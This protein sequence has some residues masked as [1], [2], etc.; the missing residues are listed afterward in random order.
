MSTYFHPYPKTLI[1]NLSKITNSSNT[2]MKKTNEEEEEVERRE[3]YQFKHEGERFLK[4]KQNTFEE[5]Q[6]QGVGTIANSMKKKRNTF[7]CLFH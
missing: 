6:A 7:V 2:K 4:K 3:T 1:P 5:E